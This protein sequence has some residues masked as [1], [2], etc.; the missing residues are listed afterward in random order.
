MFERILIMA[1]HTD[2]GEFGCGGTIARFIEEKKTIFYVAF[3]SAEA[4]LPPEFPQDALVEEVK[5]ATK[6]IGIQDDNLILLDFEVRKFPEQR[7]EILDKMLELKDQLK[8]NVVF[9]PSPND[10]HQDHLTVY[11]E[12]FRAF[13]DMTMFGYELPWNNLTFN[14]EAF[15]LLSEKHIEKKVEAIGKYTS[16]KSR[17][18]SKP[19]FI[20][21]L[22]RTRGVQI[23][24][25]YAEAFE[26]VRWV[27]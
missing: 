9:L 2:D 20:K 3:S 11:E 16:Q 4:S 24:T 7:Q 19:D 23:G 8:P 6:T 17:L 22:A 14:T 21:G 25:T 5:M 10:T 15:I 26:M 27:L 1:P 18:Y 12:G 13:K